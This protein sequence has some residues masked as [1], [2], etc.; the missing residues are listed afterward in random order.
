MLSKGGCGL[1]TGVGSTEM[2][3]ADESNSGGIGK[4]IGQTHHDYKSITTKNCYSYGYSSAATLVHITIYC[5]RCGHSKK[6]N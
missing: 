1:R 4:C 2:A 3:A 6:I 5:T